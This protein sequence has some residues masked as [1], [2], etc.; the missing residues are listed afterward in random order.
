MFLHSQSTSFQLAQLLINLSAQKRL[1]KILVFFR[2]G[3]LGEGL[4]L[5]TGVMGCGSSIM[6]SQPL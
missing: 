3:E 4:G 2:S 1:M 6:K 5:E